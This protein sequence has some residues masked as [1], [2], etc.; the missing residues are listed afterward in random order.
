MAP[1]SLAVS[2][3]ENVRLFWWDRWDLLVFQFKVLKLICLIFKHIM[4]DVT[5][6]DFLADVLFKENI[7][8]SYLPDSIHHGA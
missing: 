2:N 7:S 8:S 1:I 6:E 3:E 4:V 5:E